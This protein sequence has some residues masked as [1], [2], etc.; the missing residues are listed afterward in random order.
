M[1][2]HDLG[3]DPVMRRRSTF[4]DTAE[5]H[6]HET[7]TDVSEILEANKASYATKR[8]GDNYGEW[9][10]V[11]SIPLVVYFQWQKEGIFEP[12]RENELRRRLRDPENRHFI[13]RPGRI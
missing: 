3:Y 1:S 5:G 10:R 13:T 2:S 8:A 4:H 7:H 11:A 12:G 9:E 6:F